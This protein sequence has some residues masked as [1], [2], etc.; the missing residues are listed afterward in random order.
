ME[1]KKNRAVSLP[2]I[3]FV[4]LIISIVAL[5]FYQWTVFAIFLIPFLGIPLVMSPF[6]ATIVGMVALLGHKKFIVNTAEWFF[7]YLGAIGPIVIAIIVLVL[8]MSGTLV[9][10]F[11]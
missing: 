10:R 3:S 1:N 8:S 9:L 6:I 11:M 2:I 7:S 5:I 4:F